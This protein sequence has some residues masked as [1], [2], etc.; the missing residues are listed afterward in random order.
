MLLRLMSALVI[1]LIAITS[2]IPQEASQPKKDV[3]H[4]FNGKDF[5]G[6]TT[7]LKKTGRDD[8]KH[9]FSVEGGVIHVSGADN[10]YVATEK[11][12]QNYHLIV[13]FKWG[14]ETFGAKYVRNSG[15]LLHATGP[16]GNAG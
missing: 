2:A 14:K 13:E 12:Y 10:G 15:I 4:L 9:V 8:P 6:L 5:T 16:D 3:I 1:V 11:A 7:W